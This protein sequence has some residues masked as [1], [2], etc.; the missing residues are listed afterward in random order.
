MPELSAPVWR[1]ASIMAVDD[2][3]ANLKLLEGMLNQHGYGVRS[4]PRARLALAAAE[5]EAPDLILLDVDMPEMGGR[6]FAKSVLKLRPGVK[7]LLM[8][9]HTEEEALKGVNQAV[10]FLQKPYTPNA[11]TQ[12]VREILGLKT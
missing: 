4:F 10:A 6:E 1:T 3:P 8:S 2:N 7:V 5:R 12:K 9:G 11:L